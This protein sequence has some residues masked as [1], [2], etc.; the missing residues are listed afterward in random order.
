MTVDDSICIPKMEDILADIKHVLSIATDLKS[1]YI[2]S[3]V[4]HSNI[5]NDLNT[6]L[7]QEVSY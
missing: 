1:I 2:A 7:G 3:D 4:Q 5:L 6:Q